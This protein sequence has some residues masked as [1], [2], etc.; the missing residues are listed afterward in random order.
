MQE[1]TNF[2]K[3]PLLTHLIE[4]RRRLIYCLLFFS[5]VFAACYWYSEHI[6]GFLLR[7]LTNAFGAEG[8]DHRRIIYTGL[9]EAFFTYM[10]LA[11]FS[12]L[13]FSLPVV[14]IQI[15]R[16]LAPGLYKH[17]KRAFVP[18][19]VATP[20]LFF[21]GSAMAYYLVMPMAWEFFLGFESNKAET[22]VAI[23]LEARVSE[24]LALVI[25]LIIAF[26][27][28]F[29]LPVLLMVLARIGVVTTTLLKE[30]RR[31]AIVVIFI[32]AA[33]LTPPD[34][35]S[36][37]VLGVPLV[38]LYELSIWLIHLTQADAEYADRTYGSSA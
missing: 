4:L 9:H 23:Q 5:V 14:L 34:L 31:H 22:G 20:V 3:T 1:Q 11:F 38:L 21:L 2:Q 13:F 7:P 16:F 6:Y 26:G 17:E 10:K 25:K 15:W 37:I 27:L 32:L 12:A 19:L 36:Q 8:I 28:C 35:I 24:Y 33:V 18:L 30:Y 29:E